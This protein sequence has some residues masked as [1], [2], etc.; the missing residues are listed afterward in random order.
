[1]ALTCSLSAWE[2]EKG[3]ITMNFWPVKETQKGGVRWGE[4]GTQLCRYILLPHPWE[5][6]SG[7]IG[8]DISQRFIQFV[9]ET[10]LRSFKF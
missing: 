6:K 8:D 3:R 1:M 7:W 9:L 2:A 5:E 10:L 4:V